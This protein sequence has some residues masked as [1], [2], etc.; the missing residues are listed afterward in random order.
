MVGIFLVGV[1]TYIDG[2]DEMV[3]F[4]SLS[5]TRLNRVMTYGDFLDVIKL[6]VKQVSPG[7][8]AI[9]N[10]QYDPQY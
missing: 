9:I 4:A 3:K 7:K 8:Y 10:G 6:F 2:N 1:G 5:Y